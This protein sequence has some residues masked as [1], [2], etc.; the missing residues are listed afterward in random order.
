[1][2]SMLFKKKDVI[3]QEK[4]EWDKDMFLANISYSIRTPLNAAVGMAE[5]LNASD[6]L[7]E[8]DKDYVK[9]LNESVHNLAEIL[10]SILDYS[11]NTVGN[12]ELQNATYSIIE[13]V[14]N[15]QSVIAY[16]INQ[17]D[18]RFDVSVDPRIPEYLIGDEG[19]VRQ[20]L[21][22]LLNNAVKYT[23][24]GT[25]E[26][27]VGSKYTDENSIELIFIVKDT[28][29]GIKEEKLSTLF[30]EFTH[31]D[32]DE[33][34]ELSGA[35]LG[36]SICKQ[37][38]EIMD[39]KI[40]VSSE[41]GKGSTFAAHII[42]NIDLKFK[43][44]EEREKA[45]REMARKKQEAPISLADYGAKQSIQVFKLPSV[46][47]LAVDDSK[48]NL[49]VIR[50]LLTRYEVNFT[51]AASGAEAIEMIKR[52]AKFDLIFMD[53]LMP[54]MDGAQTTAAIRELP[55]CTRAELPIIALT[56]DVLR[57]TKE[58][59]LSSGMNDYLCKPVNTEELDRVLH[60]FIPYDKRVYLNE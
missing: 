50:G 35:G 56:A 47:V 15:V 29:I 23:D 57:G 16:K 27:K 17:K 20:I 25:I 40:T 31:V 32:S 42:Q 36:L 37:L 24:V 34:G 8:K 45:L 11:K 38:T 55:D 44:K 14:E 7:S 1:M 53:Y 3:T 48:I 9:T 22:N 26:L 5:L 60:R 4:N 12:I 2:K 52:G 6:S 46:C 28:G 49:K 41:Y 13:L 33:N 19:R 59:L 43:E 51:A 10:D 21:L 18:L 58:V 39:G 54:D 30:D